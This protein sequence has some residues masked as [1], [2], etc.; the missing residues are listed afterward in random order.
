MIPLLD[1][2][3][4]RKVASEIFSVVLRIINPVTGCRKLV[5]PVCVL[6]KLLQDLV[7][8]DSRFP[9]VDRVGDLVLF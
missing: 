1:T 6:E 5:C 9:A 8:N 3:L 4:E 2:E 7:A